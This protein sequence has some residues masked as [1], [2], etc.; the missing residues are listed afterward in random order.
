MTETHKTRR[1]TIIAPYGREIRLDDVAFESGMRLLRVTI[2]EGGRYTILDLDAATVTQWSRAMRDWAEG[3]G[4]QAL[5]DADQA[6]PK[7]AD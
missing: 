6:S 3:P 4:A 7:P 1:E 5:Q 2:R